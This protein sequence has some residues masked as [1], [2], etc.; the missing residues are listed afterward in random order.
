MQKVGEALLCP[1]P[2]TVLGGSSWADGNSISH[3]VT[4]DSLTPWTVAHQAHL[5]VGFS[6]QECWSRLPFPSHSGIELRSPALQIGSL[7]SRQGSPG[8]MDPR[9]ERLGSGGMLG[10][11]RE[12]VGGGSPDTS[13]DAAAPLPATVEFGLSPCLG[14][15]HSQ[16]CCHPSV[17]ETWLYSHDRPSLSPRSLM[18]L[19]DPD[20]GLLVLAGK[21]RRTHPCWARSG[22][23]WQSRECRMLTAPTERGSWDS[24]AWAPAPAR[25]CGH[26]GSQP[27]V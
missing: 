12:W 14:L 15:R 6:S 18:P 13:V 19:L 17:T 9:K 24:A 23:D 16:P 8:Q 10:A 26:T 22:P 25:G 1:G 5:P 2:A 4:S 7:L 21:V 27:R 3:S 11:Q 20:S